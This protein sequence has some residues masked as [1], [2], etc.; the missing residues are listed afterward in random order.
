MPKDTVLNYYVIAYVTRISA[1]GF[2][3]NKEVHEWWPTDQEMLNSV[4]PVPTPL[5]WSGPYKSRHL[6][7]TYFLHNI[8]VLEC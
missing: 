7:Y 4:A 5:N 8:W 2:Y 3:E 6:A 1:L